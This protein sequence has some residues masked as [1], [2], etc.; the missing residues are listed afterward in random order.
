MAIPTSRTHEAA[1]LQFFPDLCNGCGLCVQVCK[2]FGIRIVDGKA[3]PAE[4]PVFGCIGCGHCMAI[5]PQEAVKVE[6]RCLSAADLTGLP[7]PG[8]AAGYES[9]RSLLQ[10]RRAI[11]EFHNK[12]VEPELIDRVLEAVRLA[13]MGLPPS[14]VHVL[15]LDSRAKVRKF[16][17]DF[18]TYLEGCKW[19]VSGW[20]LALMRPFWGK[21]SDTLFRDFVRPLIGVYTSAMARGEDLVTYDAPVALYFYGSPYCDPA[22]PIVAATYAML[23]AES[24]GLGTCMLG[25]MHPFIQNGRAARR[26]REQQGIRFASREGLMIIMGYPR[27]KYHKGIRRSLAAVDRA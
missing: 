17:R 14:D 6:G 3:Q 4:H 2:D 9:F 12:E 10:R 16:S 15:V 26:F 7:G 11:R 1:R 23:A 25:G 18:C 13:P 21:E 24:L 5:C 20:F 8:T 19:L 22:D 27:V